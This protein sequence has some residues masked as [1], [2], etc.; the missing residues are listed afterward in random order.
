MRKI[1]KR[2]N[3]KDKDPGNAKQEP[4]VSRIEKR[5]PKGLY[6]MLVNDRSMRIYLAMFV[7]RD[8]KHLVQSAS[9][10]IH[11]TRSVLNTRSLRHVRVCGHRRANLWTG[12]Q[13]MHFRN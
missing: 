4:L 11:C 1:D 9:I 13:E 3:D 8:A 2:N 6:D 10:L 12:E 5:G 7:H